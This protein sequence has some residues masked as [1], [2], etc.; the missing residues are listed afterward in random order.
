MTTN[1]SVTSTEGQRMTGMVKWFNNK[2]GF[3]FVTVCNDYGEMSG[4]DVFVH[5]SSIRVT[6]SQYKY[7]VQGEYI[8]FT[9]VKSEN[10]NHEFHGTDIC[11]VKG[12]AIMCETRKLAM[13]VQSDR[14]VSRRP[15]RLTRENTITNNV[16][17]VVD[18]NK[19]SVKPTEDNIGRVKTD[20]RRSA[21]RKTVA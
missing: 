14:D 3:G 16:E 20:K 2:A 17:R 18:D 9:L 12:G 7:L 10:E 6:N 21:P 15:P 4:K 1:T 5:Y 8:D 19:K 13:T 11:G